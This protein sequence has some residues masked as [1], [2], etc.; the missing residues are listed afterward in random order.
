[1]VIGRVEVYI[2]VQRLS[3]VRMRTDGCKMRI[4]VHRGVSGWDS[5][6]AATRDSR[7]SVTYRI[8]LATL[9]SPN[10]PVGKVSIRTLS[11]VCRMMISPESMPS[12]FYNSTKFDNRHRVQG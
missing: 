2:F 6:E 9:G 3:L 5:K 10:L 7:Y 4:P 8:G 12:R 1:M 11:L